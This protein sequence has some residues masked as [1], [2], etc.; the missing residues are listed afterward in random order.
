MKTPIRRLGSSKPLSAVLVAAFVATLFGACF[1]EP[2]DSLGN[3]NIVGSISI[4]V[5]SIVKGDIRATS[6]K[7]PV[8]G[9]DTLV[10]NT[11]DLQRRYGSGPDTYQWR[12]E[13]GGDSKATDVRGQEYDLGE[14]DF[15][16]SLMVVA[17]HSD[18]NGGIISRPS[19]IATLPFT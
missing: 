3:P 11:S 5:V 8:L 14:D 13:K 16:A 9:G 10:A 12:R 6:W 7:G 2:D 18:Y 19:P 15:G 4:D 17:F 1:T